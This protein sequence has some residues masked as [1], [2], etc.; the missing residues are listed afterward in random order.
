[1]FFAW[2]ILLQAQLLPIP[3]SRSHEAHRYTG[4]LLGYA[5]RKRARVLQTLVLNSSSREP[6]EIEQVPQKTY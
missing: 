2:R 4:I 3:L 5:S 6:L 1:M